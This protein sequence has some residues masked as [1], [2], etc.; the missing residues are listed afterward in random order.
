MSTPVDPQANPAENREPSRLRDHAP[1]SEAV[2]Y[3]STMLRRFGWFYYLTGIGRLLSRM[4]MD[5]PSAERIRE[6]ERR[7]PIV[8]VLL[9][10]STLDHLALNTALN[11]RRLPLS[12]WAN[13]VRS[14]TWQP[15]AQAWAD[16]GRR[17][18]ALFRMGPP[19]PVESGWVQRT[20][21]AGHPVTV[22][23]FGRQTMGQWLGRKAEP[24]PLPSLLAAQ[25][26]SERPIQLLPV[27]VSWD[28]APDVSGGV[29]RSFIQAGRERPG[30]ISRLRR[31]LFAGHDAHIQVGEPLDLAAF[32]ER[33]PVE[34]Q[35]GALRAV[36]RR[37]LRRE[38]RV[39]RGPRLLPAS[40]MQSL[41]LDNPPMRELAAAE[42]RAGGHSVEQVRATM[43]KE[44]R[45]I[46]AHFRWWV[47]RLLYIVLYPLWTR[48]F[49]GVDIRDEDLERIRDASR[50]GAA[51]IIPAHKSHFD[52]LL[53]SWVFYE[54]KLIPPH[55]VA[56]ENL[57]IWPVSF[58]LRGAGG[59]FI[60]R[61]FAGERIHPAV[62]N[63]YLRELLHQGYPVEFF[64]EGGRTRTGKL[65]PP[66]VGVLGMVLE[67]ATL[68][69]AGKDI[70]LLPMS[71]AYEQ[72]AEEK[73]YAR[74]LGG[75][76]KRPESLQQVVKARSVFRRRFGK[77]YCR[78]G[79]PI[80]ASSVVDATDSRPAWDERPKEVQREQLQRLG[81]RVV[82]RIG[83][84]TVVL[85][86]S[87]LA[88]A[89]MA[90][91]RR[92]IKQEELHARVA[93]FYD[94]LQRKGSPEAGSMTHMSQALV[95]AEV[96]F[97]DQGLITGHD[98]DGVTVW[99][100]DV[101]QR[102]TLAFYANML[103]H[104]FAPMG[105]AAAAIRALAD[106]E[107]PFGVD[108]LRPNFVALIWLLRREFVLDPDRSAT[109][110]LTEALDDLVAHGALTRDGD[111]W[112]IVSVPL[113]GEVY[114][115]FRALLEGYTAVAARSPT[116]LSRGSVDAR[117]LTRA[118]MDERDALLDAGTVTRP[119]ALS[120]DTLKNAV[121][122]FRESGALTVDED[123][124]LHVVDDQL[125]HTL[126]I[127]EPMVR[128]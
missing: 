46:A 40:E 118:L 44:Y 71:L 41:V 73:A 103:V 11:R 16:V 121:S 87:L 79:E 62:F 117:A 107:A 72:V 96:R 88:L 49:S 111:T 83:Q 4:P 58:F 128:A 122:S 1:H 36:L 28:R 61:K 116:H 69:R 104:T 38:T 80:R 109:E 125:A 24:D 50:N 102:I 119:E 10:A 12:L 54:H 29:V 81:E 3:G 2:R 85:P 35:E 19:D 43:V 18:Q 52:Y 92:G 99:G 93:R 34:R 7:G 100:I 108:A 78:V 8:Y 33:V 114:G 42:A 23:I 65:L 94:V 98:L 20:V 86:T 97:A 110:L 25:K 5:E 127:L 9:S 26:H 105:Y 74:E 82:Y 120:L 47:I 68:R 126:E 51:V 66:K 91:P 32:T 106:R 56:G 115:L 64:I 14:F 112:T 70:T 76:D 21:Q 30:P 17:I 67:A 75:E 22:F 48:V 55:V 63:R 45:H 37:Y 39:I 95:Q 59:F 15:V 6:A 89:L 27:V 60:K 77:V 123:G 13:G 57:A 124:G 31:L 113:L 53:L 84:S 90:H 101:D